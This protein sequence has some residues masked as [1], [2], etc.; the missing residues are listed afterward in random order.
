MSAPRWLASASA[1]CFHAAELIARRE[2]LADAHLAAAIEAPA[3][4]LAR[5][6]AERASNAAGF[7]AHLTPLSSSIDGNRP[8]AEV[9]LA[10]ALGER[11]P[12]AV[13]RFAGLFTELEG[14]F[15]RAVPDA[16]DELALRAAPLQE[17]WDARGP[18]LLAGV[19]R[20]T[21]PEVVPE[22]GDVVVVHPA[23]G[24]G[25]RA[26]LLYNTVTIEGVLANPWPDLPE[27][28][29][30]GWLWSQLSADLPLYQG[31]IARDRLPGV[32][33]LALLPAIL[34]AAED[35]ELGACQPATIARAIEAW[36]LPAADPA[37]LAEVVWQW[38]DT[39]HSARPAWGVAL[40]ALDRMAG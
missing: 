3:D 10:K 18:G 27:V 24:G 20:L 36:R 9:V 14:A 12:A 35:V 1:S 28:L 21:E 29:R 13:E 31:E 32:A 25:G 33:E 26:Y 19:R 4:A 23:Q 34:Q 5:A 37:A 39:Y 16:V 2:P 11:S 17:Q 6:V 7:F 38:W 40:A 15:L 30:L 22:A 8:L